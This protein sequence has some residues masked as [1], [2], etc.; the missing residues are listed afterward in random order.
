MPTLD[1]VAPIALAMPGA[2]EVLSRGRRFWRMPAAGFVWERPY[3]KADVG[4]DGP[5]PDGDLLGVRVA[6]EGEKRALLEGEPAWFTTISH[7]DGHPM[8]LLRLAEV[9]PER[10]VEIVQDAWLV[11]AP[12]ELRDAWLAA[13]PPVA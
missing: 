10:L 4:R 9:S 13:H 12:A 7:F 11:V 5:P 8:L 2:A 6:D 1:D 3:T